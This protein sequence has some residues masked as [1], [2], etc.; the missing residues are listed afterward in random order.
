MVV[1]SLRAHNQYQFTISAETVQ[2]GPFSNPVTVTT[3]EAGQF[4][5]S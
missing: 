5:C 4:V 2:R 1:G 3:L